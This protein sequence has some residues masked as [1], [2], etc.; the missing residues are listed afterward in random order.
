MYLILSNI[1]IV[2][3][4]FTLIGLNIVKF[5]CYF[6]N[7]THEHVCK[8][9]T[10]SVQ[11]LDLNSIHIKKKLESVTRTLTMCVSL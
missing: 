4:I 2:H 5:S 7:L 6:S 3:I 1:L 10:I 8:T 9:K 11:V